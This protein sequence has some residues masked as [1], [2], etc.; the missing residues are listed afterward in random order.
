MAIAIGA[1]EARKKPQ[2]TVSIQLKQS[3]NTS[4]LPSIPDNIPWR[5]PWRP[6]IEDAESFVTELHK[7]ISAQHE[8]SGV[9]VQAVGRRDDC[10]DVLFL[11]NDLSR[12]LVVVHLTWSGREEIDPR[13]PSVTIFSNW[14]D[15]RQWCLDIV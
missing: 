3:N 13:W 14:E 5:K 7:E 2:L 1:G 12:P 11:T 4:M 15:W 10:D 8:L 6:I 9:K